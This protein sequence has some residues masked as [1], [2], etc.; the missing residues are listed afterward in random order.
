MNQIFKISLGLVV[1]ISFNTIRSEECA[2]ECQ[3]QQVQSYF[4][5]LDKVAKKGS[6]ASDIEALLA[7]THDSVRYIHVQY[8][9]DFTK[10]TWREAFLRNLELG[11]YQKTEKNQI[12]ILN[13]ISGKDHIAIEYSHGEINSDGKWEKTDNYLA[14]FGFTD[15]KISL[16]KELW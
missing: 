3:L 13:S 9:A 5:A 12:R 8:E 1:L 15:G 16:I 10:D 7:L 6:T 14:L 4:S 2:E 11:R